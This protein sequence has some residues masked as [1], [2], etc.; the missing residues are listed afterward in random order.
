MT[1]VPVDAASVLIIPPDGSHPP[2]DL[3]SMQVLQEF[4]KIALSWFATFQAKFTPA[5]P[6]SSPT[7]IDRQEREAF[8]HLLDGCC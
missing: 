4:D 6:G 5:F 1:S 8:S 3:V 7:T 2:R